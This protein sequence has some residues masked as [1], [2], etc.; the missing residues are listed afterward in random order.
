MS[1][2]S[3]LEYLGVDPSR[4]DEL[5]VYLSLDM[6]A[7]LTGMLGSVSGISTGT[8]TSGIDAGQLS[9]LLSGGM[10]RANLITILNTF[11]ANITEDATIQVNSSIIFEEMGKQFGGLRADLFKEYLKPVLEGINTNI[12]V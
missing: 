5:E 7:Q 9:D 4:K 11:G 3:A 1:S 12:T 10:T 6:I 8:S 2:Y